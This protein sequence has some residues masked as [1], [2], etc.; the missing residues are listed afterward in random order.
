MEEPGAATRPTI[1]ATVIAFNEEADLEECLDSLSW[2]DEIVFVDSGS[3]DRTVEIATKHR[4]RLFVRRFQ[5]FSDQ[6]NFAAG[7]ASGK[8]VLSIDADERVS[9]ELQEEIQ[10]SLRRSADIGGYFIPRLNLWLSHPMRHGGWYPDHSLRLY[11]KDAGEW[12]G[13][14]HEQVVVAGKTA[15]LTKPIV[16]KTIANMHDHLRKGLLSSVLELKEAKNNKLQFYWLPPRKVL[17]HCLKDFWDGPKTLLAL[18]LIYKRR[19]KNTVEFA[20]LLPWYPVLRFFYMYFLRLGFLDGS[21]GFWLA[22]S[23]AVVEAM[24]DL[25]IW[26]YYFHQG[27]QPGARETRLEDPAVLYRSIS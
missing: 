10:H 12:Q 25:K 8:W 7:Q 11:R 26:E 18:R 6:K 17:L 9:P 14:S 16:H 15:V 21:K 24:K 1:S 27:K 20:W 22:Y 5:G 4:V 3:T 23:S 2:C 19:L 13:H